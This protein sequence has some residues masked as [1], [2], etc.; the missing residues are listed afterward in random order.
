MCE[1]VEPLKLLPHEG[2]GDCFLVCEIFL[3]SVIAA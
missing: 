1:L 3:A 2:G